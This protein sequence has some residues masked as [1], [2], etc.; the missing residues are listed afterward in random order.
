M[1]FFSQTI[2]AKLAG[3]EVAASLLVYMGFRD[4]PR[5]WWMGFGDLTAGGH[6]WQGT[7][8]MIQIDGL[9][10]AIGTV[11]P[12][13]T[14]TLSGVD[15]AI[16]TLARQSS[17]RVKDRPCQVFI[18]FFEIAP[19]GDQ[20]PWQPLD[21][22]YAIWSGIMDQMSYAADGPSQRRVTLTAESIWTGRRRPAYGFWTDRDQNAR[23]PGDRGLEQVVNLVMKTVRWPAF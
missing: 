7:G 8:E 12:K 21:A 11:A 5:H 1:G 2:E 18:Q 19:G 10:S 22:P 13:T 6:T 16:V 4:A 9:E 14:F 15:S 20:M 17:A 23:F 3:R